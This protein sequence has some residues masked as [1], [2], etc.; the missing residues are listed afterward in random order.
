MLAYEETGMIEYTTAE[1]LA[2]VYRQQTERIKEAITILGDATSILRHEFV[3]NYKFDI[4]VYFKSRQHDCN[5][6]T[7]ERIMEGMKLDAW[8]VIL[9]RINIR[10]LMSSKR[11][12]ELNNALDGKGEPFPDVVP[13]MIQ[14]VVAGYAASINEFLEEAVAEEYEFWRPSRQRHDYK[15]NSEYKLNKKIIQS[16]MVSIAW[17]KDRFQCNYTRQSHI[18]ALDNIFHLLAGLGPVKEYKGALVTAIETAEGGV[19]ETD[20]F[21]FR[22]YKNGNLHL[23]FKRDDI[24]QLFNIIASKNRLGNGK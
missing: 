24:L 15:R 8:R 10:R 2:T 21:K 22:C 11:V 9:E 7:I 6:D 20:F 17:T 16:Y 19:G 12:D 18:T 23:E 13:E 1:H 14:Q 4:D 3:D 5:E